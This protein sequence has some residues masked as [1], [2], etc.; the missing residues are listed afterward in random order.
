M[1]ISFFSFVYIAVMFV[2][3]GVAKEFLRIP[4]MFA[5]SIIY[6]YHL[7]P[8][9]AVILLTV[10][11]CV[12]F[13]GLIAG[14]CKEKGYQK[15]CGAV[16][17]IGSLASAC[18]LLFFK[19]IPGLLVPIG[20]SFY[21]FSSISYLIDIR[22]G[23]VKVEK[24]IFKFA[25]FMTWCPKFISGPI[26]RGSSFFPQLDRLKEVRLFDIDV[27]VEALVYISW[28]AFLKVAIADNL[29]AYTDFV[30]EHHDACGSVWMAVASLF[31]TLQIYAD[32]AG[33]SYAAFGI[34]LL[35]GLR[36]TENFRN[37]YLAANISDFWR[38]WHVSLSNFFRD[39]VYIPLGGS[40]KGQLR[41]ILNLIIVFMLSGIW[42]GVG[43]GFL[44]WGGLHALYN[45]IYVLTH[46]YTDRYPVSR[47]LVRILTFIGVSFAWIFFRIGD[48]GL[49]FTYIKDMVSITPVFSIFFMVLE[50]MGI[51]TREFK[52]LM[53]WI[54]IMI[55]LELIANRH[56]KSVP[57]MVLS[58]NFTLREAFC[59]FFVVITLIFGNYGPD[60]DSNLIYMQF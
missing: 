2:L 43:T 14:F 10:T 22:R 32:F 1:Q 29:A 45:V 59:L 46:R 56:K 16:C 23:D 17:V 48:A 41:K 12:Y 57:D 4:I 18:S 38:R 8:D 30:F 40:R 24:N 34:S 37:P 54:I 6:I 31:Y 39:Y 49:A 50:G 9:A 52:L 60:I 58:L 36:L 5:G 51:S 11:I 35:F 27:L 33:Y 15:L 42:H 55:L 3:I 44:I 19:Y 28:G 20:F 53:A 13:A 47:V 26:E 25:L 7:S 21:I